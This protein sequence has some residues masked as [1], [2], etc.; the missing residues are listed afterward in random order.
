MVGSAD[1]LLV[2]IPPERAHIAKECAQLDVSKVR[3]RQRRTRRHSRLTWLPP[4]FS[5]LVLTLRLLRLLI[6]D[7]MRVAIEYRV[8]CCVEVARVCVA[9]VPRELCVATADAAT[10][11]AHETRQFFGCC[12][13]DQLR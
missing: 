4:S 2:C 8:C 1:E 13:L 6:C 9:D 12:A 11:G 10:V 3:R 7:A 5:A